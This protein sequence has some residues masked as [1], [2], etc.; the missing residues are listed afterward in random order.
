[1]V[2]GKAAHTSVAREG[3]NAI[4]AMAEVVFALRRVDAALAGRPGGARENGSLTVTLIS[5]GAG[6]NVVP[7]RCEIQ[8]DRRIVPGQRG[9]DALA[10][11]DGALDAVRQMRPG[12]GIE[13]EEPWLLGDS[14]DTDPASPIAAVAAE[15]C[16]AVGIKPELQ[17]VPYGSDASK[18]GEAGIPALVFGP[19]DIAYAHAVGEYMPIADLRQAVAFY[20]EVALAFS[21]VCGA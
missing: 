1:V 10:E 11:I 8:Y 6:I 13:R 16:R 3:I 4:D 9:Q 5:G 19:G 21:R 2:T 20:R 14:L 15:A 17:Q 18:F 12:V 7:E